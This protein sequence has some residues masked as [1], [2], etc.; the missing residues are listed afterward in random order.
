MFSLGL[1]FCGILVISDVRS[2]FPP[3]ENNKYGR[4]NNVVLVFGVAG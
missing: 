3:P 4:S 2:L 1:L